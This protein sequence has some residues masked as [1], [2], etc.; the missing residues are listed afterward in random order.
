MISRSPDASSPA[1]CALDRR[2]EAACLWLGGGL[3]AAG[4]GCAW[5]AATAGGVFLAGL[6]GLFL[7][8]VVP[9][10]CA[11]VEFRTFRA[12]VELRQRE[13]LLEARVGAESLFAQLGVTDPFAR[14]AHMVR[15]LAPLADAALLLAAAALAVHF[16]ASTYALPSPGA[17]VIALLGV[18]AFLAYTGGRYVV[19]LSV[20]PGWRPLAAAGAWTCAAGIVAFAGALGFAAAH[21]R[22]YGVLR[23]LEL[24]VPW[25]FA[26]SAIERCIALAGW[27][28][29]M[30]PSERAPGASRLVELVGS[31]QAAL[32]SLSDAL[33]YHFG[34]RITAGTCVRAARRAVLPFAGAFGMV[35]LVLSCIVWTEAGHVAH[36]E[37]G[38]RRRAEVRMPG[39][40]LKAPWPLDRAMAVATARVRTVRVGLAAA[41][42]QGDAPVPPED[43]FFLTPAWGGAAHGNG[44]MAIGASLRY[45]VGDSHRFA[46]GAVDPDAIARIYFKRA[47]VSWA[48]RSEPEAFFDARRTALCAGLTATLARDLDRC[49]IRVRDVAFERIEAPDAQTADAFA[50]VAQARR[51]VAAELASAAAAR[52]RLASVAAGE[53]AASL[54]RSAA[55]A[56]R[57]RVKRAASA[58]LARALAPAWAAHAEMLR[59]R[60]VLD[61][62]R[63]RLAGRSRVVVPGGAV[64]IGLRPR[65]GLLFGLGEDGAASDAAGNVRQGG[66]E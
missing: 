64:R 28:Y 19:A 57:E 34:V 5:L 47:L 23:V 20:V 62:V 27:A 41:E 55:D 13:K 50:S 59:A 39:L 14:R 15:L 43:A 30:R 11:F 65:G 44:L 58:S 56:A 17:A 21:L 1:A 63:A 48:A 35:F 24:A 54:A 53:R 31:P 29:G 26:L 42:G 45:T 37:R 36:I 66:S 6:S 40:S 8:A 32:R 52:R 16:L 61:A 33:A 22:W 7:A 25:W 60:L 51:D 38:G 3:A 10:V 9:V 18:A 49:G 4:A 46:Y 12:G 2:G